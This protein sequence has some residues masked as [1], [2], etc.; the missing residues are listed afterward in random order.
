MDNSYT[1]AS[2]AQPNNSF[3]AVNWHICGL[4]ADENCKWLVTQLIVSVYEQLLRI[5]L[6][7]ICRSIIKF[8]WQTYECVSLHILHDFKAFQKRNHDFAYGSYFM[9]K[10]ILMTGIVHMSILSFPLYIPLSKN[11]IK[12]LLMNFI[13]DLGGPVAQW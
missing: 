8:I 11:C 13:I 3:D 10:N 4:H 12:V 6:M 5:I 7:L 9:T 1:A 2:F